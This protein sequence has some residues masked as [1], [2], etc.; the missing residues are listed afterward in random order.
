MDNGDRNGTK[1]QKN[2]RQWSNN[3]SDHHTVPSSNR[4]PGNRKQKTEIN[5]SPN[6]A[7][8]ICVRLARRHRPPARTIARSLGGSQLLPTGLES[9]SH[10]SH[11]SQVAFESGHVAL[12]RNDRGKRRRGARAHS[13]TQG[14]AF[15]FFFDIGSSS[16]ARYGRSSR[17]VVV[18]VRTAH[19]TGSLGD[20]DQRMVGQGGT[21]KRVGE[22]RGNRRRTVFKPGPGAHHVNCAMAGPTT[23][24]ELAI[25]EGSAEKG[26]FEG[27]R[28][29]TCAAC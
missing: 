1:V 12:C 24:V 29:G 18:S 7:T 22:A 27:R 9:P 11:S 10:P 3:I 26:S 20:G 6:Y 25:Q 23:T 2:N 13:R 16:C 8:L 21:R 17:A 14:R 5:S 28:R 4:I 19:R 15:N